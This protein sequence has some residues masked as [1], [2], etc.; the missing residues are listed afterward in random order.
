[1]ERERVMRKLIFLLAVILAITAPAFAGV[2]NGDMSAGLA[3]LDEHPPVDGRITDWHV[4]D[5]HGA[6]TDHSTAYGVASSYTRWAMTM[7]G[8]SGSSAI[9]A[10]KGCNTSGG[11][12]GIYQTVATVP[13]HSY[14][15]ASMINSM[16]NLVKSSGTQWGYYLYVKDGAG[17]TRPDTSSAYMSGKSDNLSDT[18][19][20]AGWVSASTSF[21]AS[22]SYTTFAWLAYVDSDSTA[23]KGHILGVDNVVLTD[24]SETCSGPPTITSQPA[25]QTVLA[26]GTAT[27]AITAT[28]DGLAPMTYQWRNGGTDIPGATGSSYATGTAGTYSCVVSNACG[29]TTSDSA[30]LTVLTPTLVPS[31]VA[32]KGHA[33]G[34]L[35]EMVNKVVSASTDSGYWIQDTMQGSNQPCGIRVNST[36]YRVP[37]SVVT[38]AGYLTT[39]PANE[40]RI[41]PVLLDI[42]GTPTTAAAP[43]PIMITTP[44]LGGSKLNDFSL[45]VDGGLG[46]NNVG[47]LVK[48]AGAVTNLGGS[49]YYI[50]DGAG[51]KDG[52]KSGGDDN[53]GVRVLQSPG[54]LSRGQRVETTGVVSAFL[55]DSLQAKP[56]LLLP[57]CVPPNW[58]LAVGATQTQLAV[59]QSTTVTVANSQVGVNY[60]LR[61]NAGNTN[62][63]NSVA[64]TGGT[65]NLPTGA[66]SSTT[67]FN[68][69]ATFASGGCS[70]QLTQTVT[71][72]VGQTGLITG[73]LLS[74]K[75]W[76]ISGATVTLS[77]GGYSA[78][79]NSSGSYTLSG[80]APGTYDITFEA[81]TYATGHWYGVSLQ[82]GGTTTVPT[83]YLP[84]S[85]SRIG[86]H[87]QTENT[88]G[89][90]S[91][92][93]DVIGACGKTCQMIKCVGVFGKASGAPSGSF[94]VGRNNTTPDGHEIFSFDGYGWWNPDG[95]LR[96]GA[97][98]GATMA[99]KVYYG[100][101]PSNLNAPPDGYGLKKFMD[102][103]PQIDVWE[104]VNEWDSHYDWQADFLIKMM[105]LAELDGHRIAAF[106]FSAG[107]PS[108][109][110]NY[111]K[112]GDTM[113]VLNNCARVCARA[114]AHGGHM[115][116][117]HEYAYSPY[118]FLKDAYEGGSGTVGRFVALN[119][120]LKTYNDPNYP[121]VHAD[122]PMVVT[123]CVGDCS[124]NTLLVR[125]MAWYDQTLVRQTDYVLGVATWNIGQECNTIYTLSSMANY[126]CSDVS[127]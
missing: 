99:E 20:T 6:Q 88:N 119:A 80:V 51:L 122:C 39:S 89:L 72:Q 50:D 107:T 64:G 104:V 27:F 1:L 8:Y 16:S 90:G 40:R 76:P 111:K 31:V 83:K 118:R 67:T 115:L 48:V 36:T 30:T 108:L 45:G 60:Q 35:I 61:N 42:P 69:L 2:L 14:T 25:N 54:T 62:V 98:S 5:E 125:D 102:D 100:W 105:D 32:A 58:E 57:G 59:G 117:I 7:T 123:E 23:S 66:L 38:V 29:P 78:T 18:G 97:P 3:V 10:N 120:Y 55:N 116:A 73:R 95:T 85:W 21:I 113:S 26:G 86:Y 46:P 112:A 68:V 91:L 126:I 81:S 63:G 79:T 9:L 37:G 121:G 17:F 127:P 92:F 110:P 53:V 47:L 65:V 106:G 19:S 84:R 24:N 93:Y 82:P 15:L 41:D 114:K 33:D 109:D 13:G 52:S 94:S 11:Y 43:R 4:Y 12:F 34:T 22:S 28:S 124:A 101:N 77:S 87:I 49:Y 96:A 44:S 74:A 103:N 71:I 75:G 70:R 56:A